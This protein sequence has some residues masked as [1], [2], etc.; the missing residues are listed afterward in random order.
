M[1]AATVRVQVSSMPE[2]RGAHLSICGP[3][4]PGKVSGS[5]APP[6][7]SWGDVVISLL[8][9]ARISDKAVSCVAL[10]AWGSDDDGWSSGESGCDGGGPEVTEGRDV[11][12]SELPNGKSES[13]PSPG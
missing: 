6:G 5:A 2:R 10:P 12:A 7:R 11:E 4:P 13:P 9:P 3:S 8:S 1:A